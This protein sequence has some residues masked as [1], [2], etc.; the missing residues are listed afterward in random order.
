MRLEGVKLGSGGADTGIARPR[1]QRQIVREGETQSHG[2]PAD[3]SQPGC[4]FRQNGT[5]DLAS[6]QPQAQRSL[7]EGSPTCSTSFAS[8][9][10]DEK[11]FTLIELLVVILIIGILAAIALPAFLSQRAKAQDSDAKTNVRT[12]QTAME[13]FYTD[14]QTYVG[15]DKASSSTSSRPWPTPTRARR[16]HAR[17][18]TGYTLTVTSKT[19]N[20][21]SRSRTTAGTV[22]RT[23]TAAGTRAAAR[24]APGSHAAPADSILSRSGPS[25]PLRAL[26]SAQGATAGADTSTSCSKKKRPPDQRRRAR[27][28]PQPHRRRRGQRQRPHHRQARRRRRAAPRHPARR[29][30][31][32]PAGARRGA[33]DALRRARPAQARPPGH[34]QPA[35]RRALARPPPLEDPK[36]LAAAVRAEAA[37][38]H[39]DADGRGHPR[40]PVARHRPDRRRPAHARRHRRRPPRDDRPRSSPRPARPA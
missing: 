35:H 16:R 1:C 9:L 3:R 11:G 34:R 19:G 22:T 27:S 21:R 33:E 29:R 40:L 39:P 4:H 10:Q 20:R 5:K 30:G 14:N 36:A 37:R 2:A 38:P 26:T 18:P 13:T 24:Q 7:Q 12:A 17:P 32:R 15:V 31:H 25:G 6:Q 8:A 23:C 28:R